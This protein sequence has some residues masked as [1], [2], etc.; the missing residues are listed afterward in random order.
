MR[1]KEVS[2]GEGYLFSRICVDAGLKSKTSKVKDALEA[3]HGMQLIEEGTSLKYLLKGSEADDHFYGLELARDLIAITIYSKQTPSSF[4]QEAMLRL[5]GIVQTLSDDYEV[6]VSSLYPYLIMTIAAQQLNAIAHVERKADNTLA[7]LIL[8]KRLITLMRENE[9]NR[10]KLTKNLEK[11]RRVVLKAASL[12]SASGM[13]VEEIA[14]ELG[15]SNKEVIDSLDMA[16]SFGQ[17]I[18]RAGKDIFSVVK[19]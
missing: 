5:L 12:Y 10:D 3:Y 9:H 8:S 16:G 18:V 7:D 11:F 4:M 17:R 19:I 13:D 15:I 2:V 14:A 6:K 1:K